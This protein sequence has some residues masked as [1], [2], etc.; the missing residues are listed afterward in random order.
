M[1][2]KQIEDRVGYAK[3]KAGQTLHDAQVAWET[4]DHLVFEITGVL[5]QA[6]HEQKKVW[7]GLEKDLEAELKKIQGHMSSCENDMAL[8]AVKAILSKRRKE[9]GV[10]Q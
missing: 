1:N 6:Q 5:A 8:S 7:D 4:T 9:A 10:D 2:L 3:K